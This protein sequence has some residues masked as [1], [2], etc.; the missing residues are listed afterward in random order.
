MEDELL[1]AKD[2]C[3]SNLASVEE[4]LATD[5]D[6]TELRQ[7][8]EELRT[9][10]EATNTT[11]QD[12]AST[13]EIPTARAHPPRLPHHAG[14]TANH[15]SR[16]HPRSPYSTSEPDFATLAQE[17]PSLRP[18]L[19]P[20]RKQP[21]PPSPTTTSN[22]SITTNTTTNSPHRRRTIDFT[23]P[24]A[25][26]ELSKVLLKKD[27]GVNWDLPE[28]HLVPPVTNR[29]NYILWIEDLLNLSS[30]ISTSNAT[31]DTR[32]IIKGLDIGCGASCIYPLLGASLLHWH[33][34][35]VDVTHE[36]I[37]GAR[38]NVE[39]NSHLKGL[40]EVRKVEM[41]PEQMD[42][43]LKY[44]DGIDNKKKEEGEQLVKTPSTKG[45]LAAAFREEDNAKETFAF[46]MCNPPFFEKIEHA[47][48][49]PS[50]AFGGT[51]VES[52]YPGGEES[53]VRSIFQDSF[54]LKDRVHWFTTLVGKKLTLKALKKWLHAEASVHVVRTTEFFQGQTSRW[55]VAWSFLADPSV[56]LKPI[57]RGEGARGT[58]VKAGHNATTKRGAGEDETQRLQLLQQ[59]HQIVKKRKITG[60]SVS[61]NIT[62]KDSHAA[63]GLLKH[64]KVNLEGS[65]DLKCSLDGSQ[66]QLTAEPQG[67]DGVAAAAITSGFTIQLLAQQPRRYVMTIALAK[68]SGTIDIRTIMAWFSG[69]VAQ[70][71]AAVCSY[72]A[73]LIS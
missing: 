19:L 52:I 62:L 36:A 12:I 58:P 21:L 13:N 63:L 24:A 42:F 17:Y 23:N 26:R 8:Q 69:V 54:L 43:F 34:V 71:E 33:F 32:T 68:N 15:N 46:S 61:L 20:L 49:N 6:N 60:R 72:E 7:V 29:L 66:Y 2:L 30:P 35:G 37:E 55:G 9:A 57:E 44:E 50:T 28:G 31:S 5:P 65:Q 4:A 56:A 47:N 11:L 45:I 14:S 41:Q 39:M 1:E 27:F 67:A 64:I 16:I 22:T 40:I 48:A 59:Q 51:E 10:L 38:K 18:Y 3:M 73:K 25:C 70:I 53:F